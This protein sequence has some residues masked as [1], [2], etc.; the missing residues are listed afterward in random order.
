MYVVLEMPEVK[1]VQVDDG[2]FISRCFCESDDVIGADGFVPA[3]SYG[4]N[5]IE[6]T[7]DDLWHDEAA[8]PAAYR[9]S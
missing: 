3:A 7:F 8:E 5:D 9:L 1:L 2:M 6:L 4:N